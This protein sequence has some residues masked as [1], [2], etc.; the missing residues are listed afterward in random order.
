M[1]EHLT[2]MLAVIIIVLICLALF[3]LIFQQVY[4]Q[5]AVRKIVCSAL[6]WLPFGSIMNALT[7]GCAVIPA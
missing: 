4:G 5:G 7:N 2:N 1:E 3:A 6:F